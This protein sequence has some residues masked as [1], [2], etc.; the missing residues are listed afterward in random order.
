MCLLA[1]VLNKAKLYLW[2]SIILMVITGAS[3]RMAVASFAKTGYAQ[4]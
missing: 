2:L 1:F 3:L 4:G